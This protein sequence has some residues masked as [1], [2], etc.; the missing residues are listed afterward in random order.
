MLISFSIGALE[1]LYGVDGAYRAV[2]EA[3]FDAV[4]ACLDHLLSYG[5]IRRQEHAPVFD[6]EGEESQAYFKPWKDAAEKYGILNFQAHAPFPSYVEGSGEYNDYLLQAMEKTIAGCE[7]IG[8]H[9][10]I[11]HPFFNGY[12]EALT[13]EDEWKLNID[14]YA[15]LIPAAKKHHVMICLEN[16]FTGHLGKLYSACC[17]DMDVACRYVDTLNNIA[18]EKVFGFCLDTGHLLLLGKDVKQALCQLG[19]RVEAL[20]VHDNNGINDQHLAPYMGILDWNRF[21]EGLRT[22]GY[23]QPLNLEAGNTVRVFDPELTPD[24]LRL[25]A[26]TARMFARRVAE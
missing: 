6:A 4:D 16:M 25:M 9:R 23:R 18:G 20:H 19:S 17:S 5:A 8:C 14:S 11:I 7:Y 12:D 1:T 10:L 13:P 22:I 15:R 21:V 26:Q 3:G 2:R 24:V